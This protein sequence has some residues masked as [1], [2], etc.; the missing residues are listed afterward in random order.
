MEVVSFRISSKE[1]QAK[2]N[3]QLLEGHH[4]VQEGS[5]FV[6]VNLCKQCTRH[7]GEEE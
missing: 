7:E 1:E 5:G 6:R 3:C 2:F 4:K